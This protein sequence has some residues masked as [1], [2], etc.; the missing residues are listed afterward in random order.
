MPLL[1]ADLPE[2]EPHPDREQE[3]LEM[4][5][6]L[7]M[8][9]STEVFRS[10]E[11]VAAALGAIPEAQKEPVR[12]P[13][14]VPSGRGSDRRARAHVSNA[15]QRVRVALA[16]FDRIVRQDML[17]LRPA[18][19]RRPRLVRRQSRIVVRA[20]AVTPSKQRSLGALDLTPW[21]YVR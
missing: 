13:S 6:R 20:V 12:N 1:R 18:Y 15:L 16:D 4:R 7:V 2:W 10:F 11:A 9:G 5:A 8:Y 14:G 21:R 3:F 19:A 17:E